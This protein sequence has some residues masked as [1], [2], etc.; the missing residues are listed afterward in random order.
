MQRGNARSS[1]RQASSCCDAPVCTCHAAGDAPQLGTM[2]GIREPTEDA[3]KEMALL[4]SVLTTAAA[5]VIKCLIRRV[6][7]TI[8][9]VYDR[10]YETSL[11]PLPR[12]TISNL[13]KYDPGGR[14]HYGLPLLRGGVVGCVYPDSKTGSC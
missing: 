5:R 7:D 1:L 14:R 13:F 4:R 2:A 12:R 6:V 10:V 3:D 9:Y 11:D 8:V